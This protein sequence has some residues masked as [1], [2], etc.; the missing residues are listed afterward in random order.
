MAHSVEIT[1][2]TGRQEP[3]CANMAT[4]L[5]SKLSLCLPSK[6]MAWGQ[7]GWLCPKVCGK[8]V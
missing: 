1:G 8:F 4:Q 3:C 2:P 5:L 7:A 6:G